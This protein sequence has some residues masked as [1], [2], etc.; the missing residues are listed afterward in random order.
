MI[1]IYSN[2]MNID[3]LFSTFWL[4]KPLEMLASWMSLQ[5]SFPMTALYTVIVCF[6]DS[7]T[8]GMVQEFGRSG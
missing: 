1:Q 5:K 2:G 3:E 6:Y 7:T 8:S 4:S